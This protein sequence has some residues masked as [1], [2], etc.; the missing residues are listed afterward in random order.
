MLALAGL[1]LGLEF[2]FLDPADDPCAAVLGKHVRADYADPGAVERLARETAVVTTEFENVPAEAMRLAADHVPT[3]PTAEVLATAQDRL[4][5]KALIQRLGI[6]TAAYAAIDSREALEA[7]ARRGRCIVKTRRMGYDGKGQYRV[8]SGADIAAAW[9][10]LGAAPLIAEEWLE[11][12]REVS[13]VAVRGRDGRAAFYP[14]AENEHRNGV[15][16]LSC[17][18]PGDPIQPQAEDHARRI[19]AELDYVGVIAVEFFQHG[20]ALIANEIAPRVHNTGHWTIEGAATS[21]FENHLRAILGLPLGGTAARGH[22]AMLNC[23][24]HLPDRA[25]VLGIPGAHLHDYGKPPLPGR[26]VGHITCTG[27]NE[28]EVAAT[29]SRL[30]GLLEPESRP[31]PYL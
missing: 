8:R 24:G 29:M 28:E 6:P 9:T 4:L 15:L 16:A 30:S 1:P 7:F 22:S 14:I 23:L 18:R 3:F 20:N 27:D 19:M 21:Q 31:K 10:R 2:V 13:I 12:D 25:A 11:F 5:E 26:K 17:S